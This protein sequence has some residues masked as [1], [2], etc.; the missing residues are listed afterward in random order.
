MPNLTLGE[1]KRFTNPSFRA[2]TA[3]SL[4]TTGNVTVGGTLTVTGSIS[5]GSDITLANGKALQSD[6]TTGHT[7]VLKAYD[8][9]GAA[10]KT[11]AT[12]TNGNTPSFAI[13]APS[14]GTVTIDGAV[15]GGTT[16]LAGSFTTL[17]ATGAITGGSSSDI[18]INT[19]KFT[20]TASSGDTLIA[21]NST[22]SGYNLRSVGNALTAVGT[23]RSTALQ[24]AKEV[25]NITTAAASTGVI[26]P[27]GVIGMRIT[28]FNAGAN[29][30]QVYASGSETI[31]TVAGSTGVPLTN[32]KRCDYFF[33]AANTWISAQLGVVSA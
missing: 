7:A 5:D 20:V 18:A 17:S 22:V 30:V 14:G 10:Y 1:L 9:D 12:L 26:L 33:V 27:V 15:I 32:T 3:E 19:N 23:N 2:I 4:T 29:A 11:F 6:T 28:V 25:N 31:D 24:L 21:G 13:A 16:P 8:V